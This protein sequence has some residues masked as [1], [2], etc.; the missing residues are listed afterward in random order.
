M[1]IDLGAIQGIAREAIPFSSDGDFDAAVDRMMTSLGD[2]VSILGFGEPLHGGEEFLT[3]RNRFFQ[4]LVEAMA[5][6]PSR[7]RATIRARGSST[8]MSRAADRR[9]TRPS[10][11]KVSAMAPD[12]MPPIANSWSG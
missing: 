12:C 8:P 4:R 9:L 1:V 6:A 7:S 3:L 2:Q 11:T 5:L 10:K